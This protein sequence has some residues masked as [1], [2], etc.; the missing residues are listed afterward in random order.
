MFAPVTL[1]MIEE[2]QPRP[3][4][5]C[6]IDGD[7]INE[8]SSRLKRPRQGARKNVAAQIL[9]IGQS[10]SHRVLILDGSLHFDKRLDFETQITD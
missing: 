10:V 2:A 5:V 3:D 4:D 8:V 7:Q 1:K 6:E 9:P